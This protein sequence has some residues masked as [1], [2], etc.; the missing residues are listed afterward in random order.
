MGCR[1]G[2]GVIRQT[3][4]QGGS[5]HAQAAAVLSRI[6]HHEGH[7]EHEEENLFA[8]DRWLFAIVHL[9]SK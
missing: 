3:A 7:E 6:S 5:R 8:I 2:I 1:Q 9:H 4:S